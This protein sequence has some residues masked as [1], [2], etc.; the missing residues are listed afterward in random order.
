MKYDGFLDARATGLNL[1]DAGHFPTENVVCPVLVQWLNEAF[2]ELDAGVSE[3][4]HEAFS[5]L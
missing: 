1:I 3:I 5:Y 2:P 4:H